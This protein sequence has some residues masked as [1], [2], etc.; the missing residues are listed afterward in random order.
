MP[1]LRARVR[2]Q[3]WRQRSA[4]PLLTIGAANARLPRDDSA[5][6]CYDHITAKLCPEA[7]RDLSDGPPRRLACHDRAN[8]SGQGCGALLGS[9]TRTIGS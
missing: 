2:A 3:P 7:Y 9:C 5:L 1:M 6:Y 4:L 8:P